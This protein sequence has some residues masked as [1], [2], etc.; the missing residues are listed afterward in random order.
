LKSEEVPEIRKEGSTATVDVHKNK[1]GDIILYINGDKAVSSGPMEMKGDKMMAYVPCLFEPDA[2]RVFLIGLGIGITAKSIADLGIPELDIVEISPEVTRVAADA[3]AYVNNNILA[4]ENISITIEDGRSLLL[5][6][7]ELYDIIICSAA[8]PRLGNN[9][10]TEEFY[11]L[12]RQKLGRNGFLCQWMP[13]DW[14]SEDEFRSL[15]KTCTDVF[16]YVTLWQIAPGQNLLLASMAP[17][18]LDY[19][20]SRDLFDSMNRQG[21]LTSSGISDINTIL[22]GYLAD[23]R[24]LREYARGASANSDLHPRVEFSR[25]TGNT[26]APGILRQL[27]S[28]SVN[29]EDVINFDR[30]T[31]NKEQVLND[32]AEKNTALKKGMRINQS[33]NQ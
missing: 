12:C 15:I 16:P 27:S 22:A 19:C 33:I 5:R 11:R 28:F 21:D 30:C 32:L 26:A 20:R 31:D 2:E 8:H 13:Q 4:Y 17:G 3:Y 6:S 25:F 24:A 7:K 9:L 14:L 23:D 18:K 10:Y 1:N 29:F